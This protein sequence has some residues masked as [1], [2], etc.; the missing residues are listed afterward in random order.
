[1]TVRTLAV[2]AVLLGTVAP[3]AAQ[4]LPTPRQ[5]AD[6]REDVWGEEAV[7]HPGG[8]S[9][10]YFRDLLPPLRYVNTTFRHYPIV[11][12]APGGAVKARW[13]SNGG[14]VNLRADK[15]PMWTPPS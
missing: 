14:G 9:Y 3:L 10:E 4:P 8:P 6:A 2:A 1:M 7:R 13:V 12:S 11:L 5:M 15:P